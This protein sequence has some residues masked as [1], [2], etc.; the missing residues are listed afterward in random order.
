MECLLVVED[1]AGLNTIPKAY[2]VYSNE[3]QGISIPKRALVVEL[4]RHTGSSNHTRRPS[5][6]VKFLHPKIQ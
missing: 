4:D 3:K 1:P 2:L 6:A 5:I